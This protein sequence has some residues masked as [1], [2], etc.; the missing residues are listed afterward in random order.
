MHLHCF[1]LSKFVVMNDFKISAS[2]NTPAVDY[3]SKST[4]LT[5]SGK[6]YPENAHTFYDGLTDKLI[7]LSNLTSLKIIFDFEYLSS[8]SVACILQ[9]LKDLKSHH[10]NT[11]ISLELTHDSGD[12]DMLS[13]GENFSQLSGFP[14]VFFTR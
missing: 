6:S 9:L 13:V 7:A 1:Y 4:T 5:I 12:D 11:S 14:L 3:I 10:T 2:K 8:S